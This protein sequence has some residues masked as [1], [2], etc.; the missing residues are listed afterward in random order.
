MAG[1]DSGP[2]WHPEHVGSHAALRQILLSPA[3][4]F[5]S[6]LI[7]K[8]KAGRLGGIPAWVNINRAS[9]GCCGRKV[10]NWQNPPNHRSQSVFPGG[11]SA[12][13]TRG[14]LVMGTPPSHYS[15]SL[16]LQSRLCHQQLKPWQRVA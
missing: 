3:P 7:T 15:S 10:R 4:C 8:G 2:G 5:G 12:R 11:L 16:W 13:P 6:R 1:E 14:T 9:A